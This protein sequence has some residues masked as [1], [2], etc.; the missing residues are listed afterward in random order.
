VGALVRRAALPAGGIRL[1]ASLQLVSPPEGSIGA[2]DRG[3]GR[4]LRLT[5][6]CLSKPLNLQVLLRHSA[7]SKG[8]Q[9]PVSH[10]PGDARQ[11]THAAGRQLTAA[12]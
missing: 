1:P 9:L 8:R 4:R 5:S 7:P 6:L 12:G 11:M 10:V 3:L 2:P